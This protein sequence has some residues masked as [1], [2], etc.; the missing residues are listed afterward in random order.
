MDEDILNLCKSSTSCAEYQSRPPKL[1]I[2]PST[3]A[4]DTVQSELRL[5]K[6]N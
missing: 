6:N 3:D 1:P 4:N 2:H 5:T